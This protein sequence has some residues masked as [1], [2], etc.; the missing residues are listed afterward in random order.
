M[1]VASLRRGA[2]GKDWGTNPVV[3]AGAR[4]HAGGMGSRCLAFVD[5]ARVEPSRGGLDQSVTHVAE[6]TQSPVSG[7]RCGSD[8]VTSVKGLES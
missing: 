7:K 3:M 2:R 4:R 5:V 8:R 1:A 6:P